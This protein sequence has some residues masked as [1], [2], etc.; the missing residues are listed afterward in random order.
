MIE[1]YLIGELVPLVFDGGLSGFERINRL[2]SG[3]DR[4]VLIENTYINTENVTYIAFNDK[5]GK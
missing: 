4:F 1:V 3:G 2:V 5:R